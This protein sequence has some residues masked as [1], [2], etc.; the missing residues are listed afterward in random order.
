MA[1]PGN[2]RSGEKETEKGRAIGRALVLEN[3]V[4]TSR[5]AVTETRQRRARQGGNRWSRWEPSD[6]VRQA[7]LAARPRPPLS[8]RPSVS[9]PTRSLQPRQRSTFPLFLWVPHARTRSSSKDF[10]HIAARIPAA[11]QRVARTAL[12]S[13]T[14]SLKTLT[15]L[16]LSFLLPAT[17]FASTIPLEPLAPEDLIGIWEG[18]DQSTVYQ[19]IVRDRKNAD[20]LH[21]LDFRPASRLCRNFWPRQVD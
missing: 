12:L 19:M 14:N 15:L 11:R 8:Q 13:G 20:F 1:R 21:L 3:R 6:I 10:F 2:G 9:P 7:P 17:P 5:R 4:G 16:L 18:V